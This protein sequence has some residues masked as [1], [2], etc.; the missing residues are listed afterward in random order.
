MYVL[1]LFIVYQ[2]CK[3][4]MRLGT[5]PGTWARRN[6][7]ILS[8]VMDPTRLQLLLSVKPGEWASVAAL[9][10]EE[11]KSAVGKTLFGQ[12]LHEAATERTDSQCADDALLFVQNTDVITK[13]NLGDAV[14]A[15][16]DTVTAFP[17]S[18][19]IPNRRKVPE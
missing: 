19:K 1:F 14:K 10:P 15:T 17:G 2:V 12:P 4:S 3:T 5:P 11:A 16:V 6:I 9:L 18:D 7:K 13:A 8:L